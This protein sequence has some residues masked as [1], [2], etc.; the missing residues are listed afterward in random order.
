MSRTMFLTTYESAELS[1]PPV[2]GRPDQRWWAFVGLYEHDPYYHTV[3]EF[4]DEDG[5]TVRR[6]ILYT[7]KDQLIQSSENSDMRLVEAHVLLPPKLSNRDGWRIERLDEIR[8][9]TEPGSCEAGGVTVFVLANGEEI[10]D[11]SVGTPTSALTDQVT[12]W[13]LP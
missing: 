11:S 7:D 12:I 3:I 5:G 8:S 2:F 10:T 1:I 9:A 4:H 6:A 13:S